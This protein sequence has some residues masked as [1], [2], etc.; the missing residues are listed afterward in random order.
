MYQKVMFLSK[1]LARMRKILAKLIHFYKIYTKFQIKSEDK[2]MFAKKNRI[3]MLLLFQAFCICAIAQQNSPLINEPKIESDEQVEYQKKLRQVAE[4]N[5]KVQTAMTEGIQ[6]FQDKNYELAVEKFDEALK[7]EPDYWGTSTVILT[8][9]A[10]VLRTIGVKKYNEAARNYWN[11]ANEAKPFFNN[12][13]NTLNRAL[14]IFS[15]TPIDI[16]DSNRSSFNQ[17]KFNTIKEL[18]ECYR[19]LVITD[20]TRMNEAIKAFE[21]YISLETDDQKKQKAV[22]ELEKLKG[23]GNS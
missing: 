15:A 5:L 13:V 1:K 9:K 2:K 7:F 3:W 22:N 19:L 14:Q 23:S 20:K 6:A 4:N 18:A 17:Y 8:N 21:D 11:A 10:M 16:A 12:A